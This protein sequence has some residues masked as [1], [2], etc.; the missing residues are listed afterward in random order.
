MR[1]KPSRVRNFRNCLGTIWSVST[2]TRSMGATR[3]VCL[4]KGFIALFRRGEAVTR[5]YKLS[6]LL[7]FLPG[8]VCLNEFESQPVLFP[9]AFADVPALPRIMIVQLLFPAVLDQP[10]PNGNEITR[11]ANAVPIKKSQQVDYSLLHL[12]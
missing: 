11:Q 10:F 8:S 9:S 1:P 4:V 12:T 3:P 6:I 7:G 2:L 5:P